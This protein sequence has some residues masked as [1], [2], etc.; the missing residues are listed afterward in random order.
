MKYGGT[1]DPACERC[2]GTGEYLIISI[3]EA[4]EM[5]IE[6]SSGN[7]PEMKNLACPCTAK[8]MDRST[9]M[10]RRAATNARYATTDKRDT[11]GHE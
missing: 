11:F 3:R 4:K 6:Y 9:R 5:H 2:S 8:P 1:A 7:T 10:L